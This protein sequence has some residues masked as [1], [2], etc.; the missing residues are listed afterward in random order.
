MG[1]AFLQSGEEFD[2][3]LFDA[4][5]LDVDRKD[6]S[7]LFEVDDFAMIGRNALEYP[8]G[9]SDRHGSVTLTEDQSDRRRDVPQL[10]TDLGAQLNQLS[11]C[12]E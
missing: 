7:R 9:V 5:P 8:L 11:H 3:E 1:G 10:G 2:R 4:V 12:V 6:M